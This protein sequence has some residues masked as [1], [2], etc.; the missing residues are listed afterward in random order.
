MDVRYMQREGLLKEMTS[1][2]LHWSSRGE[3]FATINFRILDRQ[4]WLS[5]RHRRRG[6]DWESLAYSLRLEWTVCHFGGQRPWFICPA[7]G[8]GVRTATIYGGR[9]YACR[10]CH[11]LAYMSQRQSRSDRAS[12]RAERILEK[13]GWEDLL[14]IFDPVTERPKGMH[15]R[16]FNRLAEQY[17]AARYEAFA[18]G[19]AGVMAFYEAS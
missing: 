9:I 7:K 4:I 5:Y 10:R 2:S 15:H 8:C 13:L 16:T 11:G 1:G 6:G 19:P 14:T 17:E 18:Y 3:R 12:A